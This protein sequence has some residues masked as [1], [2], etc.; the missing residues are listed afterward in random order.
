MLSN[1]IEILELATVVLLFSCV[2]DLRKGIEAPKKDAPKPKKIV[3]K[4]KLTKEEKKEQQRLQ[5][6]IDNIDNYT[7]DG[8]G[9]KEVK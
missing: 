7:G 5:T 8:I 1:L 9:Q 2:L 4:K 6:L 3:K